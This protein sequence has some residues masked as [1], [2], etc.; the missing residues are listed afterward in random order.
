MGCDIHM[1]CEVRTKKHGWAKVGRIFKNPY[2]ERGR[3]ISVESDNYIQ[4]APTTDQPYCGRNYDLF[5]LLADV[6]NSGRITPIADPR[7]MPSDLSPEM[8][9]IVRR[10]GRDAHSHSYFTLAELLAVPWK[11]NIVKHTG[12]VDAA[13]YKSYLTLGYPDTWAA[14]VGGLHTYKISERQ[15]KTRISKGLSAEGY[16]CLV[17]W[18]EFLGE[19]VEHFL[20]TTLKELKHL[21]NPDDVRIVFFFDN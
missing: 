12:Y 7:G 2:F 6:R 13:S 14:N 16:Y 18:T 1:Y 20:T 15:M 19:A 10:Y 17:S 21:G 8:Q 3:R 5:A 11:T 4:N 9:G